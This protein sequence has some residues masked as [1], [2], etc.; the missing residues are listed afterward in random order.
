MV[1]FWAKGM[2]CNMK[3]VMQKFYVNKKN[4]TPNNNLIV[5]IIILKITIVKKMQIRY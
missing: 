1:T 4:L 2:Y 5:L 3:C